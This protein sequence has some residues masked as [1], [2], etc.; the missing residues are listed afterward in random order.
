MTMK[1]NRRIS[2]KLERVSKSYNGTRVLNEVSLQIEV[3]EFYVIMGPNGS[4]KSTLLSIIAGTN[5][6][7]SGHVEI[8]GHN[9]GKDDSDAKCVIGYVPQDNF[10]S[11]FLTGRENLEYFAG[12]LGFSKLQV[13]ERIERVLE[14][15]Q[16]LPHADKRVANYSGGMRKKLEVATALLGDAKVL[17]LDEPSTGLD[18]NVRK[19][20]LSL[21]R[22][23]SEEG[24][25]IL[26]VTHIGEDAES[27]SK[28]GFMVDGR[29]IIE[30][31]PENLKEMACLE[32]KV[33][34][35]ALPRSQ[36]LLE[37]LA[38]LDEDCIV[39]ENGES[40]EVFTHSPMELIP[41]IAHSLQ[42]AGFKLNGIETRPPSLE[43]V[44]YHLTEVSIRGEAT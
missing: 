41:K 10:C 15:M 9:L 5:P 40:L 30:D 37:I 14:M 24:T 12:L 17:L 25:T 1:S 13:R 35:D 7:D 38:S 8:H 19:E 21:L 42:N 20:F 43:D 44:F 23:I 28:V 3:G 27:A 26:L 39:A 36:E 11:S 34:V 29:I 16:L 4:G 31:S 6:L 18:P 33:L 22:E 32:S 2:V